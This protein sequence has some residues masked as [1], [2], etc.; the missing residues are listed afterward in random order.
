[1]RPIVAEDLPFVRHDDAPGED[2]A[3]ATKVLLDGVTAA[4]FT[5]V[6]TRKT[7]QKKSS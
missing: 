6:S 4:S 7:S 2:F 3:G 5:V 1:M